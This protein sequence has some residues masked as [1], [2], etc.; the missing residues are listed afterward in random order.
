MAPIK[1]PLLEL[2]YN[3]EV[4]R[5]VAMLERKVL[6]LTIR[7]LKMCALLELLTDEAWDDE[8]I[9]AAE[10]DEIRR[11]ATDSLTRRLGISPPDAA[12]IVAER[13]EK[14]NKPAPDI[15][16]TAG[17]IMPKDTK[18]PIAK[19]ANDVAS[20]SRPFGSEAQFDPDSVVQDY[21]RR[22]GIKTAA[23]ER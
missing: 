15:N 22:K 17:K 7:D 21:L 16:G 2:A 8:G 14:Y 20:F 19:K 5:Y 6:V 10:N 12:K 18:S 1:H 11:I 23:N 13:W 3:D 4:A 9:L